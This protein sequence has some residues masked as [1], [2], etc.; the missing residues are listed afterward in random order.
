VAGSPQCARRARAQLHEN[1]WALGPIERHRAGF[2]AKSGLRTHP[3]AGIHRSFFPLADANNIVVRRGHPPIHLARRLDFT[4]PARFEHTDEAH[5][6]TLRALIAKH[7]KQALLPLGDPIMGS[8]AE[9]RNN[10]PP[11]EHPG[12]CAAEAQAVAEIPGA[13]G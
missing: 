1:P 11:G 4:K 9:V 8:Q 10:T 6:K 5:T 13:T 3:G 7:T 12:V 2:A